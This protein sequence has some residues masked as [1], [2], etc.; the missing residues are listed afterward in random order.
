M[1]SF[2]FYK[3][4]YDRELARRI[5]LDN[6]LNIPLTVLT[7]V[8]AANA[9]LIK[10]FGFIH[11]LEDVHLTHL[12]FAILIF[13]LGT[14]IFYMM[15]SSINWLKGFAYKNFAYVS[16]IREYEEQIN[17]Y[18]EQVV[19]ERNK[20]DFATKIISKLAALTDDHIIFN[21]K[22]SKDLYRCRVCLGLALI[23]TALNFIQT[24]S[25]Y[26]QL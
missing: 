23:L 10:D 5:D 25:N 7:I 11:S 2:T 22:R 18:N 8:V 3:S 15:R 19:E 14:G 9:Y 4:L 21:D 20:I 16:Q 1:D 6:A 17:A 24:V 13:I 26:I 12:I